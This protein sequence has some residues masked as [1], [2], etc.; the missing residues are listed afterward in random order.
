MDKTNYQVYSNHLAI[1]KYLKRQKE[2]KLLAG[3]S[4]FANFIIVV[5]NMI[6][7]RS[8]SFVS[9][10]IY[11]VLT[12]SLVIISFVYDSKFA[13]K[14]KFYEIKN[15]EIETEALERKIK[16]AQIRNEKLLDFEINKRIKE[17]ERDII[18]PYRY[19]IIIAFLHIVIGIVLVTSMCF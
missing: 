6:E 9:S 12:F 3:V 10:I 13:E 7:K 4:F 2:M 8:D 19:Y 11:W 15:F 16:V 18:Y 14:I 5:P 17:P 1:E